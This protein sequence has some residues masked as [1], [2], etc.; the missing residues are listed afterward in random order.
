MRPQ[1]LKKCWFVVDVR[2]GGGGVVEL[3]CMQCM[4]PRGR[5]GDRTRDTGQSDTHLEHQPVRN[6]PHPRLRRRQTGHQYACSIA[7]NDLSVFV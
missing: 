5:Q 6:T 7:V 2:G 3:C 1:V 4:S